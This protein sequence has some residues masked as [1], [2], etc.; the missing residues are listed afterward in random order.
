MSASSITRAADF[1]GPDYKCGPTPLKS[2]LEE[3]SEDADDAAFAEDAKDT[4]YRVY[5]RAYRDKVNQQHAL[6]HALIS[7]MEWR[8]YQ[9][10][11]V[12]FDNDFCWVK[13]LVMKGPEGEKR[14]VI[15]AEGVSRRVVIGEI[16]C[17]HVTTDDETDELPDLVEVP[18]SLPD[19]EGA[20]AS[21]K[22]PA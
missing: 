13:C 1:F 7:R 18:V 17:H 5:R 14:R 16:H 2:S 20:L 19:L 11:F 9:T 15:I 21:M 12:N 3:D 8:H 4:T 10:D 22:L 6:Q